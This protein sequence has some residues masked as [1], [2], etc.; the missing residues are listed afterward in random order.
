MSEWS[1]RNAYEPEEALRALV[2]VREKG[3]VSLDEAWAI[4]VP[5][6][7]MEFAATKRNDDEVAEANRRLKRNL[8][9]L[10][11]ATP[12][13]YVYAL[14]L[15]GED[16]TISLTSPTLHEQAC[17]YLQSLMHNPRP[18]SD[19]EGHKVLCAALTGAIA[20]EHARKICALQVRSE[21]ALPASLRRLASWL[22]DEP[23]FP[24]RRGRPSETNSR[25][26]EGI[27]RI[28][29]ALA[30]NFS[31]P[32]Q[33]GFGSHRDSICSVISD[34]FARCGYAMTDDAIR[35]VIQKKRQAVGARKK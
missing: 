13:G 16:N 30:E 1:K 35:K 18:L 5:L 20:W 32:L 14:V 23:E 34:V 8:C 6:H 27:R 29:A 11:M 15:G 3:Q 28:A 12:H 19:N 4:W 31:L 22:I 24:V 25:R 26:D 17:Y 33:S 10:L 7:V 2:R 21:N 9:S